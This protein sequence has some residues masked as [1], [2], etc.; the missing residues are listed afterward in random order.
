M[1]N[2]A[3]LCIFCRVVVTRKTPRDHTRILCVDCLSERV[4]DSLANETTTAG[5]A[6]QLLK[7]NPPNSFFNKE[8]KLRDGPSRP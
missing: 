4:R 7:I 6:E 1:R 2:Y 3:Y 8:I 5:E